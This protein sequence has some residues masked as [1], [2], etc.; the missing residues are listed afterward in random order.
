[1]VDPLDNGAQ[2]DA[3][4]EAEAKQKIDI[5]YQQLR[6]GADF[7]TVA[8]ARSEDPSNARGGDIGFATEQDL[9][10]NGF[11]AQLIGE[12]FGPMQVGSFTEPIQF[13]SKRWY[14][15]KLQNK[16]L[17]NENLTLDS[18]GVRQQITEALLNQRKQIINAAL[19]VVA[20]NE[21][22]V[23]NNLANNMLNSPKDLSGLRPAPQTQQ[24]TATPAAGASATASPEAAATTTASPR[25]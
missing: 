17:Q 5:I 8:R 21:A 2:D 24:T 18:P 16:Q 9:Q 23:V 7:A 4:S 22:K 10:Q 13:P 6:N 20:M 25:D 3:K 1:M 19:L 12:F 15:F 11:P 14:I